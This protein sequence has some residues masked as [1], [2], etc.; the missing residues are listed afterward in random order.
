MIGPIKY[1]RHHIGL[2]RRRR[3]IGPLKRR[4]APEC[5]DSALKAVESAVL[6]SGCVEII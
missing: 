1:R 3:H 2:R 6:G 5:K 4:L